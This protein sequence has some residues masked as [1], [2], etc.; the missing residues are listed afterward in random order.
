MRWGMGMIGILRVDNPLTIPGLKW[1][2]RIC[3]FASSFFFFY[4]IPRILFALAP[5]AYAL[6]GVRSID[7]SILPVAAVLL[8]HILCG[9]LVTSSVSRNHRHTWWSEVYESS[10]SVYMATA[11]LWAA[12]TRKRLPFQ[13]TPKESLRERPRL[14]FRAALPQM[15]LLGLSV[16]GWL[17]AAA[18]LP[19]VD[20]EASGVLTMNLLWLT[21]NVLLLSASVLAA[22]DRPQKRGL[23]RLPSHLPARVRWELDGR[24]IEAKGIAV[25]LSEGGAGV[26]LRDPVPA[27]VPLHVILD[28]EGETLELGARL[29]WCRG[30]KDAGFYGCS[31]AFESVDEAQREQLILWMFTDPDTWRRLPQPAAA[32]AAFARLAGT[33][34]RWTKAREREELR[35]APRLQL[36]TKARLLLKGAPI[37]AEVLD[38][39]QGGALVRCTQTKL[40]RGD[41]VVV[42]LTLADGRALP[43][44]ARV[45][46]RQR[47]GS[48]ALCF[49]DVGPRKQADL[50]WE[51]FASPA[52]ALRPDEVRPLTASAMPRPA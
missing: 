43:L 28:H 27:K 36:A 31:V 6:L 40:R 37:D 46:R 18:H 21:Y 10:M 42:E 17:V 41:S 35:I 51:L 38:L 8:P 26:V 12:V 52:L 9:W 20:Y 33:V 11:T 44:L 1:A 7:A 32:G 25:D 23:P 30:R 15:V 49:E 50:L 14:S 19:G 34:L 45:A 48:V 16:A 24:V 2:Q 13:V 29:V 3:Y 47:N 4:G 22:V 5:A 39:S